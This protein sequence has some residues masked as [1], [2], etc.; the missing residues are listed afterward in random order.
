[1]FDGD[2]RSKIFLVIKWVL[3][4]YMI[5]VILSM[6]SEKLGKCACVVTVAVRT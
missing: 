6:G 5:C 2:L 3:E 4:Q 1:M